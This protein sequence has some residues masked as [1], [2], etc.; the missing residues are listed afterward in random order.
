M[1]ER[2]GKHSPVIQLDEISSTEEDILAQ[3]AA[4]SYQRGDIFYF[5]GADIVK[6]GIGAAGQFLVVSGGIPQWG[7]SSSG[8][9]DVIGPSSSVDSE[10]PRFDGIT[11]KLL[12][13]SGILIDDSGHL[14]PANNDGGQLGTTSLKWS[15]LF[16]ASGA[17]IDFNSGDITLTHSSNLLTLAGGS[18]IAE[19]ITGTVITASTGLV[20]DSNDSAYL[21]QPTNAFSDLYLADGGTINFNNGNY[22]ITHSNNTLTLDGFLVTQHILSDGNGSYNLGSSSVGW[23]ILY[24]ASTGALDFGAGDITLTHSANALTIAGGDFFVPD[25]AYG[26]GWNGDL[27]VPTKNAVYDKIESM[28]SGD[29]VGPASST[30]NAVVRFDSTTGKLIQNSGVIVS[31]LDAMSGLTKINV[32]NIELDGNGITVTNANADFSLSPNGSGRLNLGDSGFNTFIQV[33]VNNIT[34][35]ADNGLYTFH[36][37]TGSIDGIFSF[38]G[39]SSSDKTFTFPNT[40]GN[41]VIDV[42]TQTLTNKRITK[43]TGTVASSATPTINTDN[44]DFYSITALATAITSMTTNLSGTPTEGQTLWIAITDNGTAR[45]ITWGA[46]FEDS[47]T[48]PLPTTTVISTR[49]DVGLVWNSV[50]SKWRCVAVA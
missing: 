29:V 28:G 4:I 39:L 22:I 16:L 36:S 40:T 5:D 3:L 47:G 27:S 45:A 12:K 44:V 9:G 14:K 13:S 38:T 20:P 32:D 30:D 34:L 48:I 50:T 17:V 1:G 11:G 19:A 18:F 42:A 24:I 8:S 10:V 21:G 2:F 26:A 46:S 31:D 7:G 25:E 35:F 43:R 15:D 33:G 49:L 41:V 37:G 6:L 23:G